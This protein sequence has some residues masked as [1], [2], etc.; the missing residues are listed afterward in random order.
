[1]RIKLFSVIALTSLLAFSPAQA[2]IPFF[3]D[4][5]ETPTLAPMLEEVTPAVVNISVKGSR[6]VRQRVPDMFR[7]FF[8]PNSPREQ[9]QERPFRGLGSGVIIDADKGYVVTNNHVIDGAS[10]ILVTLKDGTQFD[11]EVIGTDANSDIALL[12]IKDGEN[13]TEIEIGKS[14]DLRVGDFVVAIGNPFGLGQTVTSGIVSALGR[15]GLGIEEIENFIQTDAAINSG[16]S[17]GALVTLKGKLIGINTAILGPNGGNIGIGFAIPSDMMQALVQQLIE[18]GEVRRGV[19][20]VRGNDL[21]A[22]IAEALNLDA[23]QGAFIAEVL[24]DSA[25]AEAGLQSG[26]VIIAVNGE[27]VRSFADL[28]ARVKTMGVGKPV[29]LTVL[30]DGDKTDFEVT[31]SAEEAAVEAATLHP[32]LEGATLAANEDGGVLITELLEGSMAAR[33]GLREDDIIMAVN[34]QAVNSV[35]ELRNVLDSARGV[36]ALN[37]R[38]GDSSLYLVLR[39]G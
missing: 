32:A 11:A 6:E 26:D 14:S 2:N 36:V 35:S 33:Y 20:G 9:V 8:G 37:I 22:D 27:K 15:S 31:L 13:L 24:P 4:K 18:F 38:R 5:D 30:R 12:K 10:E 23:K 39:G 3:S 28:S 21:T 7:F 16:N 1:M 19:L 29:R 17:G 25:A 34:R